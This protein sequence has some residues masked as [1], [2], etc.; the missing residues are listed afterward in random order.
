[1][2]NLIILIIIFILAVYITLK[3]YMENPE[4]ETFRN[5]EMLKNYFKEATQLNDWNRDIVPDEDIKEIPPPVKQDIAVQYLFP[6]RVKAVEKPESL[7]FPRDADITQ[8]FQKYNKYDYLY[9]EPA[10]W[11]FEP[12]RRVN[13][14][15]YYNRNERLTTQVNYLNPFQTVQAAYNRPYSSCSR[16][17]LF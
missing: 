12:S 7:P 14:D 13:F 8:K 5:Y 17:N 4:K 9:T 2:R 6:P 10:P 16:Y 11:R 15:Q 3:K 1:M